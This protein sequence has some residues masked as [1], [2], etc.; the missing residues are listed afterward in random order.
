M[1][2]MRIASTLPARYWFTV[3][4]LNGSR[5][6]TYG[7]TTRNSSATTARISMAEP[8][9]LAG[10]P[11]GS[12]RQI[13]PY[14]SI[15]PSAAGH[16]RRGALADRER[17]PVQ[18]GVDD[19]P[20]PGGELGMAGRQREQPPGRGRGRLVRHRRDHRD[21]GRVDDLAAGEAQRRDGVG[22]AAVTDDPVGV[23]VRPGADDDRGAGLELVQVEERRPL[24]DPVPRDRDVADR[25]RQ[26][27]V[28]VVAGALVELVEVGAFD[29]REDVVGAE[30]RDVDQREAVAERDTAD[31]LARPG[32]D[33]A[34]R[35]VA[36]VAT[37]SVRRLPAA[38]PALP[39]HVDPLL[40]DRPGS[41]G[42]ALPPAGTGRARGRVAAPR[43]HVEG[44][45]HLGRLVPDR[46][47]PLAGIAGPVS[48][49]PL[50]A[51]RLA[52]R[53]PARAGEPLPGIP[54]S[55]AAR[56]AR[57][58]VTA[59]LGPVLDP[60]AREPLAGPGPVVRRLTGRL[61]GGP[62][63]ALRGPVGGPVA[64]EVV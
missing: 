57:V 49:E 61:L 19:H 4:S 54:P 17:R 41:L 21:V 3:T 15:P 34:D 22:V 23:P 31:L 52:G 10:T 45:H 37:T 6:S 42:L 64:G 51:G 2:R 9:T 32:R 53:R 18:F 24:A 47:L 29:D 39:R 48:G 62:R 27:G 59:L 13:Q 14:T 7:N 43:A 58:L 30:V 8:M 46:T 38:A 56:A 5:G 12:L 40:G 16:R 36:A 25:A 50:L 55:A 33:R 20:L 60:V 63:P 11:P 28:D 44:A 35:G 1:T 26:R